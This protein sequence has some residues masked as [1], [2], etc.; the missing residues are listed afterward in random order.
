MG[1]RFHF[2]MDV[3]KMTK[4]LERISACRGRGYYLE[5]LLNA[6]MLNIETAKFI[7]SASGTKDSYANARFKIVI[8]DMLQEV[9]RSPRLKSY[10]SKQNVKVLQ[11][12]MKKTDRFF[13]TLKTGKT[14]GVK[15]LLD[16]SEKVFLI[17]NL[18]FRKIQHR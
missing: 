5:A 4:R 3:R 2:Y 8:E 9:G 13:K 7:L 16:E 14:I 17:L 18:S 12:W 11:T 15:Q 6:Y 1:R 10:I